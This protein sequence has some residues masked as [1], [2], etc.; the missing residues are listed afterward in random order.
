MADFYTKA[1]VQHFF[2]TDG[3]VGWAD[4][5][6]K[7]KMQEDKPEWELLVTVRCGPGLTPVIK[8][9]REKDNVN[10]MK[11]QAPDQ[12]QLVARAVVPVIMQMMEDLTNEPFEYFDIDPS[13]PDAAQKPN[14]NKKGLH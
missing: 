11:L 2:T 13:S 4:V 14:T 12:T 8:E 10:P 3:K 9:V 1:T 7:V 5:L 6:L